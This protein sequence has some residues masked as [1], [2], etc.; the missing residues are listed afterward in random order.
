MSFFEKFGRSALELR[1]IRCLTVTGVLIALDVVLKIFS[2]RITSD[3][4]ITFAYL[5]LATIGMLFGP[6]VGFLAGIVTD[7]V[8]F[9][10]TLDGGGGF[11]P[12]FTLI[13]A[14]GAMIYG[15][16]LYDL[17]PIS[18]TDKT[19]NTELS[20]SKLKIISISF[21]V[22]FVTAAVFGLI[23]FFISGAATNF[24]GNEKIIEALSEPG[25]FYAS[26]IIG[27]L[28]GLFFTFIILAGSSHKVDF[29]KSFKVVLSKVVVVIVCNLFL[30]P[31]AMVI[32]GYLTWDS[33]IVGYPL[34]LVKNAIQCPLDCIIMLIIMFPILSAYKKFARDIA[35]I[36]SVKDG[37]ERFTVISPGNTEKLE[38]DQGSDV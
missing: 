21:A 3:L 18:L 2:I 19:E 22:G 25:L 9:L 24:T 33:L 16:F 36:R 37:K 1:S 7:L 23:V 14:I 38:K 26:I 30:T 11:S 28:Y 35:N 20:F 13:E 6:T 12:L 8:G 29:M 15:I 32:T 17:K 10:F 31:A 5:A 4:K 27:F 34:R